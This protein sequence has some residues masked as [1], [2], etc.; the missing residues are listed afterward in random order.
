MN[1][2]PLIHLSRSLQDTAN[3]TRLSTI[4]DTLLGVRFPFDL[5]ISADGQRVAF[6]V[7]EFVPGEQKRRSRIWLADTASGESRPF[8]SGKQSESSPCWSPDG[9]QLAFITKP[10]GEKAQPQLHL[11]AATGGEPRLLCTMPNG[12]S[13]LAWAPDG[14]RLSFISL[15]GDEPKKDPKVLGPARHHRLWTIRPDQAV[16]EP[17]TQVDLT[18]WEYSW[19]PDSQQLA[20]Y[21]SHGAEDTDWYH[22][23]IG[24]VSANGGAVR[25]VVH[26]TWQ[27]RALAWSLDSKHLAY[28]SG[29]WSDPG[30]GSGEIFTVALES[31]QIRNLTPGIACSPSWCCWLP[32]GHHLLYTAV[33]HTTH[34]VSLLDMREGTSTVLVDD[35]IMQWDQPRLIMTPDRH[36]CA[37]IHSTSQQPNDIWLGT[38]SYAEDLPNGIEWKR[39]SRLN[40]L[41]EE[42]LEMVKSERIRYESVDGWLVDGLFTPALHTQ[43]GQ[44][45]P[46]YVDV[47]GGPSGASCDNW[48]VSTHIYAARG[49]AT[50]VPNMRGS[51]GQG[52]AFADAVLGDMGG[53]DLQDILNGVEYLVQ[54]GKV[55]GN[56]VCIGGWS[57]GGYLSACA[58]T[59][60]KRFRAAMVG[61][62][63][64]DW[65]NMHAQ[66]NIPDA[67]ILL[68][69]A[70]P[71]EQPETYHQRSPITFAQNV[72]TPTLI[73]HGEDDPCV[74]VA[75]A[76]AFYRALL[77]RN[78]PVECVVYPREGHGVSERDHLRDSIER[79][80]HWFERHIQ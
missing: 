64:S 80:L 26:L 34:Q 42:T 69:G 35:F 68:L 31:G 36:F 65:H 15:E 24:I 14:S 61:A 39:L 49:F 71:L 22:S 43:A 6:V 3:D 78:V 79:Q 40:S 73:L 54:Q 7:G 46:L 67:D 70:T 44:L 33:K 8:L 77:E 2:Q 75:Q 4:L 38:L 13:E 29:R 63:I 27:A 12:V 11:V 50:F 17:V 47:H 53:K 21:Y 10:E 52:M 56:R 57:N 1:D 48:D 18:V 60:S 37:T 25:E 41:I 9:T 76:Y 74:P 58:V 20:L 23:H 5:S 59:Q 72:T 16:P 28:I 62:G 19:S 45:P 32:D 51:W 30:R 66:S 55:D